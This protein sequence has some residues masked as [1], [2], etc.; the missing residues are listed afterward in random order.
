MRVVLLDNHNQVVSLTCNDDVTPPDCR[1][2]SLPIF[3]TWLRP[4]DQVSFA[5]GLSRL[6]QG[7]IYSLHY[8]GQLTFPGQPR[9][10]VS[11][12]ALMMRPAVEQAKIVVAIIERPDGL[13]GAFTM[14]AL[15]AGVLEGVASGLS[16]ADIAAALH[17]TTRGV[18]YHL[19]GLLRRTASTN[20]AG[21]VGRAFA[22]GLFQP[23]H[24]PPRV[25]PSLLR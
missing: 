8:D 17:L 7:R 24:W 16:T 14:P 3:P 13:A 15:A 2:F 9:I 5:D 20:R 21:L 25:Q 6:R 19:S 12:D 1:A 22:M 11:L 18:E 4:A 23:G 10:S